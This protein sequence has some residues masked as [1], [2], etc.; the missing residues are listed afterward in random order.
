M[1]LHPCIGTVSTLRYIYMPPKHFT[2]MD[3]GKLLLRAAS[4][5]SEALSLSVQ[6]RWLQR[7]RLTWSS[8]GAYCQHRQ[9]QCCHHAQRRCQRGDLPERADY[10]C[11][12]LIN[13]CQCRRRAPLSRQCRRP[14][15][16][17]HLRNLCCQTTVIV[18]WTL[19]STTS[20][21]IGQA[22]QIA[23]WLDLTPAIMPT[24]M[25]PEMLLA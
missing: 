21:V 2:R 12:H 8:R 25:E 18:T 19:C 23:P 9:R 6:R 16:L 14:E 15:L 17:S 13:V 1:Y 4:V 7:S 5:S 20:S 11:R 10:P 22:R 24:P 3:T